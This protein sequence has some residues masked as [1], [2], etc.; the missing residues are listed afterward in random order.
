[1]TPLAALAPD[2]RAVLELVLRQDRSY[3]ELSELLGIPEREVRE[4][5]EGA[6][7]SLA[8]DP[9]DSGVDTGRIT[10]WLLGQQTERAA[11][12]TADKVGASAPA[13][14]WAATVAERLREVGGERVPAVPGESAAPAA[15]PAAPAAPRPRPLRNARPAA[16]GALAAAAASGDEPR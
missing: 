7:R 10:D 9:A 6:L 16:A 12:A 11:T 15:A 13:R 3:G 4:R 8:G 5:A 14:E 2:Q 1:M